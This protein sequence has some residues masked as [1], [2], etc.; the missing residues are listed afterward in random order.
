MIGLVLSIAFILPAQPGQGF[1]PAETQQTGSNGVV[2]RVDF[3]AEQQLASLAEWLDIW[4]VHRIPDLQA[5]QGYVI[6]RLDAAGLARLH[7]QGFTAI[8]Q[9]ERTQALSAAP[10]TLPG[11]TAGIPGYACYRTVEETYATLQDLAS[12]QPGLA[13]LVDIGQS[14]SKRYNLYV[15]K[16]TNFASTRPKGRLFLMGE[17]HAREYTTA[18]TATRFAEYLLSHYGVD[19]DITWL[20]DYNEVHILPMANPDGRKL[21]EG[22]QSWRKNVNDSSGCGDSSSLGTDLNRNSSFKW[23]GD[24][25][26]IYACDDTFRGLTAVSEPETA[27]LQAYVQSIFPDQRGP[28]DTDPAPSTA[29]GLFMT[30]H[31]YGNLVLFPWGYT[32]G[33]SP[34]DAA[35]RALGQ[36]FR[37]FNH[38]TVQ[39]ASQLYPTS[40]TTDD[41]AYGTLG[42]AAFTFEMGSDF[43][44][45]CSNFT[46]TI[47]PNNLGALLYALKSARQPYLTPQGPDITGKGYTYL[48]AGL[49]N[50]FALQAR[51]DA[52]LL[53]LNQP[54]AG[55]VIQAARYS[56]DAPSWIADT[57][58]YPLQAADGAF[59]AAVED[60]RGSVDAADWE[61]GYHTLFI[62]AQASSG[63]WGAPAAVQ[64]LVSGPHIYFPQIAR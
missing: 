48:K 58:T 11:Q 7:Q 49:E 26:S 21:A 30:L 54:T 12:F 1:W 37:S 56:V 18:E 46:S 2:A 40:G 35:L 42:V 5:E 16:V 59:D 62:E 14:W 3:A 52:S 22:G 19:P 38:Y 10:Q 8:L 50:A 45:P 47:W 44:E 51:A 29:S 13:Q 17:I 6:A 41:W 53:A 63:I 24:G 9:T 33:L 31:S 43:F 61:N 23:G 60:L 39:R 15:L 27:A 28:L 36:K 20:L 4:E 32:S 25:A 64:V 34:N 55:Q 57:V